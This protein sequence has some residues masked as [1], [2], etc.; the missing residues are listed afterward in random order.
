M[1]ALD[2]VF[3]VEYLH[4]ERQHRH[5]VHVG[6][7]H[8]VGDVAMDEHFTAAGVDRFVGVHLA[9]GGFDG[10][11]S[12]VLVD[13]EAF[14][15]VG[16]LREVVGHLLAVVLEQLF[17]VRGARVVS[18]PHDCQEIRWAM[19]VRYSGNHTERGDGNILLRAVAFWCSVP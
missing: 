7:D 17:V 11:V 10:Q 8:G 14:E 13:G 15:V 6:V 12:G 19:N 5:E 4:C 1:A 16:V 18:L 3:G 2:D 9:V